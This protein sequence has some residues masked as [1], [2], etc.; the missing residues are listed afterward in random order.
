MYGYALMSCLSLRDYF[1][2][3]VKYHLL[4]TPMLTI[5]WQEYPDAAVWTFRTSSCSRRQGTCANS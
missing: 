2:L 3:G 4:A 5:E 1:N